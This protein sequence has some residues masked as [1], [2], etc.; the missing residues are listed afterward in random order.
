MIEFSHVGKSYG[1]LTVF[2]DFNERI[3]DGELVIITGKSGSGKTTIMNLLLKEIEPDTGKI[4]LKRRC[5]SDVKTSEIP[6][7]R[8]DIGVVFQDFKLFDDRTVYGNLEVVRNLTGGNRKETER[9]I[10]S[11]LT[12]MGI[13][14]LHKRRPKEL[15]GGEKQKVCMARAI[16]NNP[17]VLLADEPTGNLDPESSAEV[18]K[19]LELIHRQGTTILLATHDFKTAES[20]LSR[21]R[22]IDLDQRSSSGYSSSGISVRERNSLEQYPT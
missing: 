11:V 7:Y 19:L 4:Y 12:M 8:R 9:R 3:E 22:R 18:M 17:A 10:T 2:R 5:L 6:F 21:G 20:L 14:R 1:D 15:S 13:D 16:I